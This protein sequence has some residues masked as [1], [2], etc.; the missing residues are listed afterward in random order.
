MPSKKPSK[1][2][3]KPMRPDR[4]KGC[5]TQ[6]ICAQEGSAPNA[7]FNTQG[8]SEVDETRYQCICQKRH[9]EADRTTVKT[10]VAKE[11]LTPKVVAVKPAA[12]P[13]PLKKSQRRSSS[14]RG[15]MVISRPAPLDDDGRF[16]RPHSRQPAGRTAQRK[17]VHIQA[18][19]TVHEQGAAGAF[20]PHPAEL[21]AR[22]DGRSG[23]HRAAHEGR[24]CELSRSRTIARPRKRNSVSSCA[25]ATANA[26]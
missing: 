12:P 22:L 13:R 21:E 10:P 8:Q 25:R 4:K 3:K 5:S 14:I 9:S 17:A 11:R 2:V 15:P 26:S 16:G 23:S 18:R 24:G 20:R 19:R 1:V 7:Q 6:G